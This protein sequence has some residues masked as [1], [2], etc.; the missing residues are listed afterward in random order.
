MVLRVFLAGL[1]DNTKPGIVPSCAG[2]HQA[3]QTQKGTVILLLHSWYQS[4]PKSRAL[5]TQDQAGE[6]IRFMAVYDTLTNTRFFP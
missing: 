2:D 4:T 6:I 5:R 1:A 3:H